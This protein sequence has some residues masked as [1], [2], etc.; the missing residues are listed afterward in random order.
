MKKQYVY[1]AQFVNEDNGTTSVFFPD[2]D[3][4]HTY[5][6]TLEGAALMAKDAL[7]GWVETMLEIGEPLPSPSKI[8]EITVGDG[9]VMLVVADVKN[10]KSPNLYVKRTAN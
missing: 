8:N 3:G 10:I 9:C 6:S 7:E 1:P 2:L 5:D 4:C